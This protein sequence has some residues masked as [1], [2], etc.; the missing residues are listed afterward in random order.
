M[1]KF[2]LLLAMGLLAGTFVASA[3]DTT[4]TTDQYEGAT[5]SGTVNGKEYK[6]YNWM[7]ALPDNMLVAHVSIPGTHDSAS[8]HEWESISGP[9]CS[10]TQSCKIPEM[11][12][13]GIRAWDF[14]P[15][16]D[17]ESEKAT[18]YCYH[19]IDQLKVTLQQAFTWLTSYLTSHPSEFF[20]VHLF[21]R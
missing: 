5:W 13:R 2:L 17:G 4:W 11:L 14:R 9:G 12:A 16:I 1:K 10:T 15:G 20:V 6:A 19:G 18:A 21:S 3:D 8:G 7:E